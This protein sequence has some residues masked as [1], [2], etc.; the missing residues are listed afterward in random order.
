MVRDEVVGEVLAVEGGKDVMSQGRVV[1]DSVVVFSI[2]LVVGKTEELTLSLWV[3]KRS[4]IKKQSQ[5]HL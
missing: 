1:G 3:S 2:G 4:G 5:L